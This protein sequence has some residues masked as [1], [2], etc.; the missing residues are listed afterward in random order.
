MIDDKDETPLAELLRK[1]AEKNAESHKWSFW[2]LKLL[3]H[4]L[5]RERILAELK[6]HD[7]LNNPETLLN[8]ILPAESRHS[9]SIP[10]TYLKTFTLLILFERVDE[11]G[12]FIEEGVSDQSLPVQRHQEASPG[13]VNLCHK[14]R[15]NQPLTCFCKWKTHEKEDFL[16]THQ[17]RVLVPYFDLD[18]GNRAGEYLLDDQ[19][20]L[21]W[22]KR[23]DRSHSSSQPSGWSGGYAFV[24]RVKIDPHS[25]GFHDVLQTV[26]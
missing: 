18:D 10:Q 26:S 13:K 12:N 2:S 17:W 4:I 21:P 15:P 9:G 11:I 25:H 8:Y 19:T 5:S 14:D 7:G 16:K 20:I 24:S 22:C 23:T 3:R 1:Y 6:T